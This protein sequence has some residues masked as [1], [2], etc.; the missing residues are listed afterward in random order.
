[1]YQFI[2]IEI[3]LGLKF[4]E[5]GRA[6]FRFWVNDNPVI[7]NYMFVLYT[8]KNTAGAISAYKCMFCIGEPRP[9]APIKFSWVQNIIWIL[10]S[11][12]E[13][14]SFG[15]RSFRADHKL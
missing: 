5:V 7:G 10:P 1:M 15:P 3:R 4:Y 8:M 12:R 9:T 2:I 11:D 13:N 14:S 6:C